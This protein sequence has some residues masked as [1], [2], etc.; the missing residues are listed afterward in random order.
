MASLALLAGLHHETLVRL[1]AASGMSLQGVSQGSRVLRWR[2]GH[3]LCR[4]VR[5]IEVAYAYARHITKE[6]CD[7][8]LQQLDSALF[9]QSVRGVQNTPL[10]PSP[11]IV[12]RWHRNREV[13]PRAAATGPESHDIFSNSD[14]SDSAAFH[15][16]A[17]PRSIPASNTFVHF[18]HSYRFLS[19]AF[20][21]RLRLFLA[22]EA[23]RKSCPC[24][25]PAWSQQ[26][27]LA[28]RGLTS[29]CRVWA[30]A[31]G[32]CHRRYVTKETVLSFRICV[33]L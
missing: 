27:R 12:R 18:P 21:V 11:A 23:A 32:L 1:S 28:R 19:G 30:H 33:I 9:E 14:E 10:A 26:C 7:E 5:N 24:P 2:L 16:I 31:S 15:E 29:P 6:K 3:N 13:A 22:M 25:A 20:R 17:W 4:K 8:F